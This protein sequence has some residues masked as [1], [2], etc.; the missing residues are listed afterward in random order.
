MGEKERLFAQGGS[1]DGRVGYHHPATGFGRI[2]PLQQLC[3]L[4]RAVDR[5]RKQGSA[6]GRAGVA[7]DLVV[8][9]RQQPRRV[10]QLR[11]RPEDDVQ[12]NHRVRASP[13]EGS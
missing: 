11:P 10:P 7:Y 13:T 5:N 12:C 8:L 1:R 6:P 3:A 2:G 4:P 9:N